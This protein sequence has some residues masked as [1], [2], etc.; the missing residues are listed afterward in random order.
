MDPIFFAW[1]RSFWLGVFPTILTLID[2]AFQ[3]FATPDAGAPVAALLAAIL[4][5]AWP[6]AADDIERTMRALAPIYA[7][8]IAQQRA[9]AARPYSL[10]WRARK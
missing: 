8:I 6:V 3:I 5:P 9:G 4:H 2:V 1:T 10:N 7:L